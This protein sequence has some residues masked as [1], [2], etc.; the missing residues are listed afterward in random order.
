[1]RPNQSRRQALK[2]MG[3][4]GTSCLLSSLACMQKQ[5]HANSCWNPNSLFDQIGTQFEFRNLENL[6][7]VKLLKLTQVFKH[8]WIAEKDPERPA[9]LRRASLS[10]IFKDFRQCLDGC[11]RMASKEKQSSIVFL[12]SIGKRSASTLSTYEVIFN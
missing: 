7:D 9:G 10:L 12:N 5:P 3:A 8:S 4:S 11:Y 6:A 2:I 1:M